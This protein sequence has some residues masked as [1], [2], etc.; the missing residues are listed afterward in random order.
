[1]SWIRN[2]S[3]IVTFILISVNVNAQNFTVKAY[4]FYQEKNFDSAKVYIDS[5]VTNNVESNYSKTWQLRG[6]I[7]RNLENKYGVEY[8][9][10][11]LNSFLESRNLDTLNEYKKEIDGYLINLNIRYYNDAVNLLNENK[12]EL[13][14]ETY[15]SYKNNYLKYIDKNKDFARN[16]I[17]YYNALATAWFKRNTLV[18]P[19][20]KQDIYNTA[21]K[22]FGYVIEMD[23]MNYSANYGIGISYYNLGTDLI[24]GSDPFSTDIEE[25]DKIQNESIAL[26][27]KGEPYLKRAFKVNPNEKDVVEGLTGIY[28]SLNEEN[29]YEYFQ[30]LLNKMEE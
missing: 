23:S 8:R 18:E 5:A 11:A 17:Q 1:M 13:S 25:I 6:V 9:E 21:I 19:G 15:L 24:E 22:Y 14:E 26:F 28:Y 2:I 10:I 29:E 16:D 27:K 4:K 12:L 20:K 7:Y 3:I 30:Q